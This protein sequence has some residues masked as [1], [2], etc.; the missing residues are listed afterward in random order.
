MGRCCGN[1]QGKVNGEGGPLAHFAL[2]FDAALVEIDE[3]FDDGEAEAHAAVSPLIAGSHLREAVE[4]AGELLLRYADAVV[5]YHDAASV[6]RVLDSEPHGTAVGELERIAH[7]VEQDLQQARAVAVHPAR[8]RRLYLQQQ[9]IALLQRTVPQHLFA[10]AGRAPQV[11]GFAHQAQSSCLDAAEVEHIV[12]HHQQVVACFADVAEVARGAFIAVLVHEQPGEAHD[13]IERC[14]DLVAHVGQEAVLGAL[15]ILG[16][17]LLP[18]DLGVHAPELFGGLP[19][20]AVARYEEHQEC[21]QYERASD[22]GRALRAQAIG[23]GRG[24]GFAGLRLH[25]FL[26][27]LLRLEARG[28]LGHTGITVLPLQ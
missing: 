5:G 4:D 1:G 18:K 14:T 8:H 17:V 19:F 23:G 22:I 13:G 27:L 16:T 10:K 21:G 2:H 11:E 9:F 12:D 25:E 7:E 26:L 28:H 20:H 24:F 3:L 6:I 15:A